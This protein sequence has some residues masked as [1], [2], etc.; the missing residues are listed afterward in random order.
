MAV[1]DV[2]N[3]VLMI[4]QAPLVN[5]R[6]EMDYPENQKSLIYKAIELK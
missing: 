1:S 3:L 2:T 4:Y 6:L 5:G